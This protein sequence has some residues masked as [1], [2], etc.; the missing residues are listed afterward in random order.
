M[1]NVC[2]VKSLNIINSVMADVSEEKNSILATSVTKQEL[3]ICCILKETLGLEPP[4]AKPNY[5]GEKFQGGMHDC[6]PHTSPSC[7]HYEIDFL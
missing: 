7:R 2:F 5:R 3:I 4:A 6:S 1:N